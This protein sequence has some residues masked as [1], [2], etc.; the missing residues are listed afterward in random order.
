MSH[1]RPALHFC[2]IECTN[3]LHSEMLKRN[4]TIQIITSPRDLRGSTVKMKLS[5]Y[6][7]LVLYLLSAE[8]F[9]AL[10]GVINLSGL[11]SI[12][13]QLGEQLPLFCSS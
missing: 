11:L 10:I 5:E 9:Q 2:F 7:L 12:V 3:K 8:L 1:E 13:H 6:L 4:I